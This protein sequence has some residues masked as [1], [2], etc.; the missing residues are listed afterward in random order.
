MIIL[1]IT[2]MTWRDCEDRDDDPVIR[3]LFCDGSASTKCKFM[4]QTPLPLLSN[5]VQLLLSPWILSRKI[6]S[7]KI[8]SRKILSHKI[9]F[10]KALSHKIL[11]LFRKILSRKILFHE[12]LSHKIS[13][14]K[15]L[16]RKILF[17]KILS[18]KI[19]SHK[20]LFCKML[21][22]KILFCKIL[23]RKIISC[24]ILSLFR[25]ILSRK[26]LSAKYYPAKYYPV[27]Y[28][29]AK[30]ELVFRLK[31]INQKI[32]QL[33]I[34]QLS[35]LFHTHCIYCTNIF[36]WF[37]SSSYFCT[38]DDSSPQSRFYLF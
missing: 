4:H 26:Y 30:C 29:P 14:C 2:I 35:C 7:C 21:S 5:T 18:C 10:C 38:D 32:N 19:L 6:L 9:L 33:N 12:I 23:S 17:R 31:G 13:F 16:S 36:S 20:I 22:R 25:E 28:Y 3:R 24:K 27:K 15:I 34:S 37:L 8:L 1:E 11:S